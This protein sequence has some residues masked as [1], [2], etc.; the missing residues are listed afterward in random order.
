[1]ELSQARS[2]MNPKSPS[3][4][5]VSVVMTAMTDNERPWVMEALDSILN[6]SVKPDAVLI[7]VADGNTWIEEDL[8]TSA[9]SAEVARL[10][11]VHRIPMARLGAERHIGTERAETTWV[12]FMG[13]NQLAR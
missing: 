13:R 10:V 1:M 2:M 4:I 12:A 8:R 3:T 9:H 6:Q 5:D 11:R 7:H